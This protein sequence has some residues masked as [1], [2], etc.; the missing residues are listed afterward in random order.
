MEDD[1]SIPDFLRMTKEERKKVW[2]ANPPTFTKRASWRT[3]EQA[4]RERQR[5][6][7]I[8]DERRLARC[9]SKLKRLDRKLEMEAKLEDRSHAAQGHRWDVHKARWIDPIEAALKPKEEK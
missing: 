1:L 2:E 7:R 6:Q 9:Q 5:L 4:E 8:A 3:P